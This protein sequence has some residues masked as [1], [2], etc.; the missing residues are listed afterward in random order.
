MKDLSKIRY[1]LNLKNTLDSDFPVIIIFLILILIFFYKVIF[2]N[3]IF[4]YRDIFTCNIPERFFARSM[5]LNGKLPLWNPYLLCGY[6]IFADI[7]YT[8]FYI[9]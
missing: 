9:L 8:S 7:I 4:C 3:N 6:P 5:I 2:F 1:K